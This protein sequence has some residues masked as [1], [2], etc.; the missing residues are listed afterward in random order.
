MWGGNPPDAITRRSVRQRVIQVDYHGPVISAKG[1]TRQFGGRTVVENVTFDVDRSEIVAL[2]GPNGAGKT[3]TMRMLAGLVTP[4]RGSVVVDG[5]ELTPG[6]AGT[7]R[8]R[9]GFLTESP[10]LWDRLTVRENLAIYADLYGTDRP[11]SRVEALLEVLG[12]AS[13]ASARTAELSKGLRQ[14]VA[15]GRALVHDPE[16]L[17]LDEPL[18]GLDPEV[19]RSVRALIHD[20]RTRG[21]AILLSTHNLFE[22][23]RDADR[24]AILR[25]TLVAVDHTQALRARLRPT[26]LSLR[27]DGG[28]SKWGAFVQGLGYTVETVDSTLRIRTSDAH[29]DTPAIVRQL[30]EAGASILEVRPELPHLEDVYLA[31]VGHADSGTS[32]HPDQ[33]GSEPVDSRRRETATHPRAEHPEAGRK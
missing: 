22:A 1:L 18:S 17:L 14:K 28:A 27:T 32:G 20:R 31:L 13:H 8:G 10:G 11:A 3:T 9:M 6:S 25:G 5:I 4:T 23:E 24:I 19:S 33:S 12:L 2:L 29:R 30:V 7:L 21:C 26:V 15:L 16:I